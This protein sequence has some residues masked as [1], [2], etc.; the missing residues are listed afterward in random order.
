M[1]LSSSTSPGVR[2]A[3]GDARVLVQ[4]VDPALDASGSL[5]TSKS[6]SADRERALRPVEDDGERAVDGGDREDPAAGASAM[7][8]ESSSAP[9]S[10][11]VTFPSI[12]SAPGSFA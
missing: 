12:E 7:S 1:T 6:E 8:P 9:S 5:A 11:P 4:V 10:L 3:Q 2:D